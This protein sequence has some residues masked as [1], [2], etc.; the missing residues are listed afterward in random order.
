MRG[1]Q[2]LLPSHATVR[3]IDCLYSIFQH[4][5]DRL[6]TKESHGARFGQLHAECNVHRE[7]EET[8]DKES[9]ENLSVPRHQAVVRQVENIVNEKIRWAREVPAKHLMPELAALDQHKSSQ[10]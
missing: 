7:V 8:R 4:D 1:W 10:K 6:G 2:F 9:H 5:A 3:A